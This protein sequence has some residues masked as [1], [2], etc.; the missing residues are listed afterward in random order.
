M[1]RAGPVVVEALDT[2]VCGGVVRHTSVAR[3]LEVQ[4]ME[5]CV[6]VVLRFG[7]PQHSHQ[8]QPQ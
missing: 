8:Q 5:G 4:A 2:E 6:C 1:K 7:Q 3:H